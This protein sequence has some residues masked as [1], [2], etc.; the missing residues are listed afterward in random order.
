MMMGEMGERISHLMMRKTKRARSRPRARD[1][2]LTRI[3]ISM[4]VRDHVMVLYSEEEER[5]MDERGRDEK[6]GLILT[7]KSYTYTKQK[8]SSI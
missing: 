4:G 3:W 5:T 1:Q 2:R 7:E 8:D 6:N